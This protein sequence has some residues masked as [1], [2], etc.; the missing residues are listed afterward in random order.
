MADKTKKIANILV[1]G[2]SGCG[3]STLINAVLGS[4][5]AP[6]SMGT[7]GTQEMEIYEAEGI[8]FRLI[9]SKGMEFGLLNTIQAKIQID[10]WAKKGLASDDDDRTIHAVWFCIDSTSPR[11]VS[12]NLKPLKI[13]T[14]Y[15]KN[16]P[17]IIVLTKA[18][19]ASSDE[20]LKM[21][22]E[23]LDG[24]K[25]K[26]INYKG[27]LPVVAQPF[28]SKAGMIDSEG[29]NELVDLTN[30]VIPDAIRLADEARVDFHLKIRDN[31]AHTYVGA[32]V[33]GSGVIAFS[34]LPVT[35]AIALSALQTALV[36]KIAKIFN[37]KDKDNKLIRTI[38]ECGTVSQVAKASLSM[39]KV[40]IPGAGHILNAVVAA[41]FTLA[42]GEASVYVM[43]QIY[44]GK[45]KA[46]DYDWI[47][48]IT[49]TKFKNAID[50]I[51]PMVQELLEKD[52]T[53][54]LKAVLSAIVDVYFNS[55][56]K[57]AKNQK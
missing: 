13:V 37:I 22:H 42:I 38:V 3:K 21:V 10:Q 51:L 34:T 47:K 57:K 35:D 15:G 25:V 33:V 32:A 2:N 8:P 11:F 24:K 45:K 52:K 56:S 14:R 1:M 19:E 7:H 46:D 18:Y 12:Q 5:V 30:E 27:I 49:E 39:L 43:E 44:T 28:E 6:T 54:D 4:D 31:T 50:K 26:D 29:L 23:A 40:A 16:I 17:V 48:L 20:T 36:S 55:S 9:D 53:L 41:V